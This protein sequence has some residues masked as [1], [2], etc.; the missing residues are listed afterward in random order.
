[1][2]VYFIKTENGH[3]VARSIKTRE[4]YLALRGSAQQLENL[5]LARSGNENAKFKLVQMNYSCVPQAETE[6]VQDSSSGST[7]LPLKGCKIPSDCVGMDVDLNDNDNENEKRTHAISKA[8]LEKKDELGLLML[9]RSVNKGYHLVFRRKFYDGLAE[10]HVLENQVMNLQWASGLLGIEFDAGAKDITRVFF[11]TGASPEDLLY[12]NDEIFEA[13]I[14]G[15]SPLQGEGSEMKEGLAHPESQGLHPFPQGSRPV[16]GYVTPSE[17]TSAEGTTE[18]SIGCQPYGEGTG[19]TPSSQ[20]YSLPVPCKGKGLGIEAPCGLDWSAIVSKYIEMFWDGK[21]PEIGERNAK[22]FEIAVHL[23]TICDYRQDVLEA[24][25]PRWAGFPED[26]W[27]QTI[28]N[29]NREPKKGIPA[30]IKQVIQ[31]LKPLPSTVK[32]ADLDETEESTTTVS[33]PPEP[34]KRLPSFIKLI[35]SKAPNIA[36]VAVMANIWPAVGANMNQVKFKYIDN[37]YHEPTFMCQLIGVQSI[38]KGYIVMPIE[39]LLRAIKERDKA[40]RER[41]AEYKRKNPA[42]AKKVKDPRPTDIIIQCLTENCTDAAFTQRLIDAQNN[43][44]KYL[45]LRV[46]EVEQLRKITSDKKIDSVHLLV[47]N[48]YDNHIHGQD[49]VGAD[50]ISGQAHLRFNFNASSTPSNAVKFWK[51]G[52]NDGTLSRLLLSVIQK[53]EN[54]DEIKFDVPIQGEYDDAFYAELQPYIDRLNAANGL[55]ECPQAFRL[56]K[57]MAEENAEK[58]AMYESEAYRIL[59][60]RANVLAYLKAMCLYVMEGYRWTK[61]IENFVRWSYEYDMWC[62]MHF[63]GAIIESAI[64]AE[65][66]LEVGDPRDMLALLPDEFS[67]QQYL[68]TRQREG[69]K[70]QGL[71]LLSMWKKRGKIVFDINRRVYIKC[72]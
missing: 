25:I 68:E 55:I 7:W 49:R 71:N 29:A 18:T 50:S 46:D 15:P 27:R 36:K 30:R 57:K 69:K 20:D 67:K 14:P 64:L 38:G 54:N 48:S 33:R 43:G 10:G 37:T 58:A 35:S 28:K 32:G 41:E 16:L 34:P 42:G 66:N 60:Y 44:E 9:E 21:D 72:S 2:S 61:D 17:L 40:N 3:K 59:S 51:R 52:A 4:E 53:E 39:A 26:E 47:R 19:K 63:F 45:Y 31:A 24:I 11:T 70:G 5:R 22:T 1:M 65:K 6:T 62:K 13:P 12:L 8:I 56:A 23:R